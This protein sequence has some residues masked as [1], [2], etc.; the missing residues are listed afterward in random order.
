[1]NVLLL[2]LLVRERPYFSGDGGDGSDIWTAFTGLGIIIIT[3][4]GE[5]VKGAGAHKLGKY[6][7]YLV[8]RF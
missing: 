8:F 1:M 3:R 4:G 2:L 7:R 6:A 5:P